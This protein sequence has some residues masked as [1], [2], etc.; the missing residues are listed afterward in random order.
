M[1][2]LVHLPITN[3]EQGFLC[4]CPASADLSSAN[5]ELRVAF[6]LAILFSLGNKNF[7]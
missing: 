5:L 3:R 1:L 6:R 4:A 7:Y 2:S